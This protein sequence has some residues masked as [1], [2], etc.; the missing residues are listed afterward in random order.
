MIDL[1][2][3][4]K[5]FIAVVAA[6]VTVAQTFGLPVADELSDTVLAVFDSVAAFLVYLIPNAE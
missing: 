4:R 6:G 5:A 1:R 3:Y 2:K